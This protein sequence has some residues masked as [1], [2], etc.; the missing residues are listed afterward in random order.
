MK[1]WEYTRS[2]GEFMPLQVL[3]TL[4]ATPFVV[5]HPDFNWG[6]LWTTFLIVG[7]F[8]V[9]LVEAFAHRFCTHGA[10]KLHKPMEWLLAILTS[11]VPGTGSTIGWTM[12]H[13]A[14][15]Q[16]SDTEKDPHSSRYS[17][18]WDLLVW[19]YPYN[20]TMYSARHLTRDPVHKSLHQY[21]VLWMLSW[22]VM[23]YLLVGIN[24]LFFVVLLPW[25]LGPILSTIQNYML[26]T[27]S[28]F[29]Y[30]NYDTPDNSQNSPAM[31]ILSFGA[32]GLHNNHHAKPREWS[33]VVKKGE[34][35]TAAWFIGLIKK[36]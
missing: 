8:N 13:T 11:V 35:D 26:H 16:Y 25:S 28:P 30:R 18:F 2:R 33:T 12:V 10:Y 32:C 23:W 20:G 4:L 9:C 3:I 27:N 14:H 31:H 15:H 34:F 29:N 5:T 17:N 6:L 24:G 21:Y 36:R 1:F 7:L 22:L 19:R